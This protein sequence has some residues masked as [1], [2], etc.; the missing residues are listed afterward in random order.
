MT[1]KIDFLTRWIERFNRFKIGTRLS[2]SF[3]LIMVLYLINLVFLLLV[4][5]NSSQSSSDIFNKNVMSM[6]Y[7]LEADRDF[8]QSNLALSHVIS[9]Q[10]AQKTEGVDKLWD[11]VFAN[12]EQVQTRYGK[13]KLLFDLGAKQSYL[14]NDSLF[15]IESVDVLKFATQIKEALNANQIEKAM[16]LYQESYLTTFEDARE[17]INLFTEELMNTA[18]AEQKSIEAASSRS[19]K[20]SILICVIV[21]IV[22][23]V[24]AYFVTQSILRPLMQVWHLS[25][26][27]AKGDLSENVEVFGKDELSQMMQSFHEMIDKLRA[28]IQNIRQSANELVAASG[29]LANASGNISSGAS[30]QAAAAEQVSASV[31]QM[32]ASIMQNLENSKMTEE[33]AVRAAKTIDKGKDAMDLT[34]HAMQEIAQNITIINSIVYK[35]DLLS[36]NATVEAARAGEAG[37]GFAAVAAEVRKLAE[38][39]RSSAD[40]IEKL[41]SDNTRQAINSGEVLANIVPDVNKTADLVQ[42]ITSASNEQHTNATQINASVMQLS[43]LAQ[44][45]SALS[46]EL[47]SSSEEVAAQA[48]N[49]KGAVNFFMLEKTEKSGRID[50][51]KTQISELLKAIETLEGVSFEGNEDSNVLKSFRSKVEVKSQT[52]ASSV[53]QLNKNRE[54]IS[55]FDDEEFES[56]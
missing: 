17:I 30:E 21:L 43:Q 10:L 46:E 56:I 36:I 45:Y 40:K 25:G 5:N 55:K 3:M 33:I 44:N 23:I 13:F 4:M 31:E 27:V 16:A 15:Q 38:L 8:Y 28:T 35:T 53:E 22:M 39:S 19:I 11:D 20:L 47:A 49:L 7:L 50:G 37:K 26:Q 42:E 1:S 6:N 32:F 18:Q 12:M 51:I 41:V 52:D 29:E 54:V 14:D 34:I 2:F 24:A 48:M 9:A